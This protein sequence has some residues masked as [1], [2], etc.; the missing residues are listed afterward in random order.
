MDFDIRILSTDEATR[1]IQFELVPDP[2][3]YEWRELDGG[4]CLYDKF[5]KMFIP[6]EVFKKL[7]SQMKDV[8]LY[9]QPRKLDDALDYIESRRE[10]ISRLLAGEADA[11]QLSQPSLDFLQTLDLAEL[12]F[13]ILVVDIVG[14]TLLAT[15][16]VGVEKLADW[17]EF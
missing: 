16:I 11:P 9:F 10:A 5:D 1:T 6:K 15:T 8:P 12:S 3:R 13:V 4:E 14:S 17:Q 7:V 2:R